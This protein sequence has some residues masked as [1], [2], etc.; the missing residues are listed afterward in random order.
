[1]KS[2]RDEALCDFGP[3]DI[4]RDNEGHAQLPREERGPLIMVYRFA[5]NARPGK[6]H[7]PEPETANDAAIANSE[8]TSQGGA[9]RWH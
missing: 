3:V 9:I 2:L 5:P 7:R 4:G 1:M 8:G 6:L